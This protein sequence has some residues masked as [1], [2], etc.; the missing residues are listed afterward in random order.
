MDLLMLW[1]SSRQ[2]MLQLHAAWSVREQLC[3]G[4]SS[5]WGSWAARAGFNAASTIVAAALHELVH[6]LQLLLTSLKQA[7]EAAKG[8]S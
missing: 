4:Y 3:L 2:G 5:T 1:A 7:C 8:S 6:A